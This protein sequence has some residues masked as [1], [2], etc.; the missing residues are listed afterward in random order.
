MFSNVVSDFDISGKNAKLEFESYSFLSDK[1]G[2]TVEGYTM[3][4]V[5]PWGKV[6]LR[7]V[8]LKAAEVLHML[9]YAFNDDEN[10]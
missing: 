5:F 6:K 3:S 10:K 9:S 4:L 1:D 8:G 7:P 2:R